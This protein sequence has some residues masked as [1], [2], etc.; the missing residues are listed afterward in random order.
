[1]E[2]TTDLTNPA[3]W[4]PVTDYSNIVGTNQSVT[5]TSPIGAIKCF[6]RL[7]AWLQ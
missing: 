4:T 1:V 3:S 5:I 2:T 6:Y 7:K